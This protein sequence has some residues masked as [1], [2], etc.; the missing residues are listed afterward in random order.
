TGL[1]DH[2][3]GDSTVE[4]RMDD[5]RAVMDAVGS[6]QA[7]VM[8]WSEGG[9]FSAVFAATYPERTRALIVYA[10]GARFLKAPDFPIGWTPEDEVTFNNYIRESWGSGLATYVVIPSRANDEAFRKWFGRY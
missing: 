6:Q 3:I 2:S 5:I 7:V 9:T 10:G 4:D 8:G 1:S